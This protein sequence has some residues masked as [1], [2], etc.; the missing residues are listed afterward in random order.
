[1]G[2][3]IEHSLAKMYKHYNHEGNHLPAI[4][5]WPKGLDVPGGTIKTL[6]AHLIDIY[7]TVLTASGTRQCRAC[8]HD[9]LKMLHH[10]PQRMLFLSIKEIVQS[11]MA[12]GNSLRSMTPHGNYMT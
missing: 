11:V 3:R 10:P 2:K 8:R 9:L 4:L 1:M 5:H 12:N 6:P 7:P